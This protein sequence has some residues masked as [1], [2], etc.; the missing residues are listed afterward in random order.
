MGRAYR[1]PPDGAWPGTF[2]PAACAHGI[3]QPSCRL[4]A[5]RCGPPAGEPDI[6][7]SGLEGTTVGSKDL[8]V[9]LDGYNML[10]Y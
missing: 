3:V 8:Q 7:Q 1:V 2:E 5:P 6:K 10:D 4:A 9:H